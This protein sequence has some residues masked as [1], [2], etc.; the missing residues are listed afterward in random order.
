MAAKKQTTPRVSKRPRRRG[1]A[2]PRWSRWPKERLLDL[3]LCD[4]DVRIEGT[5]IEARIDQVSGEL[6]Q[7]DIRFR[8]HYWV[9]DDWFTPHGVPGFAVPFYLLHPRLTRL[10]RSQML[11]AEGAG[12]TE[13]M[14]ILRHEVG[15]AIEHAYRLHLRR[16]RQQLFGKTSKPY[17]EVYRPKPA[18]RSYVQHLDHWYA[19]AHPDEDFAETFAVWLQPQSNWRKVYEGWP[20]MKKLVYVDELMGEIAGTRPP[21]RSR[22]HLQPLHHIKETLRQ[23]YKEKQDRYAAEYPDFYDND[24]RKLFSEAPEHRDNKSAAAFLRRTR[25]D[26]RRMVSRWTGHYEYALDQVLKEIIGRC[27]ELKLRVAGPPEQTKIDA[28]IMLTV[29]TMNYLYSGRRWL[30]I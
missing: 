5:P 18:S 6:A 29:N 9:S 1:A 16:K 4:L 25:S 2:R 8:P 10:E 28:A 21:I 20:A 15:H 11:E 7:R 17:P 26:I 23:H 27:R 19:Q 22:E 3:R 14:K 13:C 30:D 24:L 12:Q